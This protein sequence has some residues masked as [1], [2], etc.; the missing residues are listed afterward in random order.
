MAGSHKFEIKTYKVT[1]DQSYNGHS[2]HISL[3]S[4]ELSHKIYYK[5]SILFDA[6][7]YGWEK[8][9]GIGMVVNFGGLNYDPVQLS[10]VSNLTVFDGF[11][12]V[13]STE[14]PLSL[15]FGYTNLP[16]DTNPNNPSKLLTWMRLETDLEET[17]GDNE[18]DSSFAPSFTS[19]KALEI[20]KQFNIQ[21]G[22][23]P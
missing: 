9:N 13:L 1:I 22:V 23:R 5:A 18:S 6:Q 4:K 3:I 2:R 19:E 17:P 7:N 15:H 16:N 20:M 14:K 8:L 12:Q 21:P 10:I 11:Y